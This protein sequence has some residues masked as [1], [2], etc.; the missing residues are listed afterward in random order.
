MKIRQFLQLL[1]DLANRIS[2]MFLVL[3]QRNCSGIHAYRTCRGT[4]AVR[5]MKLNPRDPHLHGPFARG[6]SSRP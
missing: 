3:V 6:R 4:F 5:V 2:V 1:V